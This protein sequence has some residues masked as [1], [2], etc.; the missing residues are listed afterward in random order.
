M[1]AQLLTVVLVLLD[2]AVLVDDGHLFLVCIHNSFILGE[3]N[4]ELESLI[5]D[6]V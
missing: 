4:S 6:R 2:C 1:E 5:D 3:L